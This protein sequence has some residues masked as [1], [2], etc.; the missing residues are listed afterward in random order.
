[1]GFLSFYKRPQPRGYSNQTYLIEDNSDTSPLYFDITD[2]PANVGGGRYVIK[3]RGNGLNLR[4]GSTIDVE[5]LDAEGNNMYA[6]V[7]DYTDRFNNYYIMIEVYDITPKGPATLYLVG[8]AAIDP[9]GNQIL[10][11]NQE[12]YN[13]RWS[14]QFN[15]LPFERNVAELVFDKPPLVGIAQVVTPER[16]LISQQSASLAG[17]NF[18]VYTSSIGDYTIVTSNFQGYDQDSSSSPN[19][20]DKKMRAMLINPEQKPTTENT[21]DSSVRSEISEIQNGYQRSQTNRFNT[22]VRSSSRTIRKDFLGGSFSFF[23]S[24]S[25]PTN[26]KPTL[27]SNY[28]VSS[29]ISSQ[30]QTFAADVV[31]VLSDTEMRISKPVE[32]VVR[33]S[34]SIQ[35]QYNS[36]FTYREAANFTASVTYLPNNPQY[37]TSSLISQSY[38]E[39]TFADFKPVSG[40]VY[41]I[42]TYYKRGIATADYKQ[43]YDQVVVPIEYLT[44]AAF[45]NQTTYARRESDGRLIGHFTSQDIADD[46]WEYLIEIP[47]GVYVST[48]PQLTSASL[49]DS[50]PIVAD[51]TESGIFTSKFYQNYNINQIYTL[52]FNVTLE[53]NTELEV[54]MSSDPLNTNTVQPLAYARAFLK[55]ANLEKTR[56]EGAYNRFGQFIGKITND[57]STTKNYSR[58]EFDFETDGEGLGR[59]VLRVVTKDYANITGSAYVSEVSVKP[60]AI[61]GFNP[62]LVQFAI[63]FNNEITEIIALSQSLD[64]KI[65]YFDYTGKQSEFTTYIN[66]LV[67]NLKGEIPSNTCQA[68]ISYLSFQ[69]ATEQY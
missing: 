62:N 66:D 8:E 49:A 42:K 32:I 45:P 44:D 5:V 39:V 67:V 36:K 34:N 18:S 50:V 30:L 28:T 23:S 7:L 37:V 41:R 58:V 21:V 63:P 12:T 20:L 57:G 22:V 14:K 61:N 24:G 6:E 60:I 64:F 27:P 54:Y 68:E 55:D 48:I 3:L 35:K 10:P 25:T 43:I 11:N 9:R 59:P 19:I 65:D 31:E 47:A 56:Y 13:V 38:L 26:L 17:S 51:F 52:G 33:D 40:E 46:Y 69:G 16:A 53:P 29:S 4:T 1:M 15:V 2:F